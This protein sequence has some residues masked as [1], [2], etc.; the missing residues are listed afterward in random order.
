MARRS[1]AGR[2]SSSSDSV[3]IGSAAHR[4]EF[5]IQLHREP[6]GHREAWRKVVY[7]MDPDRLLIE[8]LVDPELDQTIDVL[9]RK[10]NCAYEL[11]V[12]DKDA[13]SEIY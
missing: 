10:T 4:P 12:S 6:T 7:D 2:P 5:G 11:K 1:W 9:D 8:A 13:Q 3:G